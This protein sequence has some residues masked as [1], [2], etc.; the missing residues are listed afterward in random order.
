MKTTNRNRN[1]VT[2]GAAAVLL[3]LAAITSI[4]ASIIPP[5]EP[6]VTPTRHPYGS[7]VIN[8][9]SITNPQHGVPLAVRTASPCLGGGLFLV[10]QNGTNV[11]SFTQGKA[12]S[13]FFFSLNAGLPV[14]GITRYTV[15][16]GRLASQM[17]PLYQ[18]SADAGSGSFALVCDPRTIAAN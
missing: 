7:V 12:Y 1:S 10:T 18:F 5:V 16:V 13:A 15:S 8:P 9:G 14:A 6:P 2:T 17:L 11:F 4:P 3:A